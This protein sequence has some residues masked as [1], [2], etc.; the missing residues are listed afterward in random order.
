[1]RGFLQTA[2]DPTVKGTEKEQQKESKKFKK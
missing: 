1:M 2:D